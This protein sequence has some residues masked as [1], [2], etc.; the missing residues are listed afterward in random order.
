M[1]EQ[2]PMA[3]GPVGAG[4]AEVGDKDWLTTLLLCIFLGTLGVHRFFVGKNKTGVYMILV[5]FLTCGIGGLIW[6]IIDL[7]AI[8]NGTFTDN[9]GKALLKK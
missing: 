4:P 1:T 6:W 9:D 3:P 2:G 5:T 8:V 7:V